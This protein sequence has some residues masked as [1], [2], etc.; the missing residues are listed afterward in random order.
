M[1]C[2]GTNRGCDPPPTSVASAAPVAVAQSQV[3]V[4]NS[5][6][7]YE[8][9]GIAF[10]N[11]DNSSASVSISAPSGDIVFDM[12]SMSSPKKIAPTPQ[13]FKPDQKPKGM[14]RAKE[15]TVD[16]ENLFRFQLAG[17]RDINEYL[18]T[19]EPPQMWEDQGFVRCLQNKVGNFMYFRGTRECESKHLPKVKLYTY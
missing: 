1:V 14:K 7:Q 19:H 2:D 10:Q 17:W 8:S 13:A 6:I 4:Q 9:V 15:W 11:N 16:V 12:E 3:P 5:N 18:S